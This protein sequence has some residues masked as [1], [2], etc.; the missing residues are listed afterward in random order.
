M[1]GWKS[2]GHFQLFLLT[3]FVGFSQSLFLLNKEKLGQAIGTVVKTLL[4]TLHHLSE[5]LGLGLGFTCDSSF[6]QTLGDNGPL[7]ETQTEFLAS[8]T[9]LAQL[10][11]VWA[12]EE[13]ISG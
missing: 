11:L 2:F 12:L 3:H 13:S 10:R 5:D 1:A 4:R 8:G 9:S 7:W 6:L